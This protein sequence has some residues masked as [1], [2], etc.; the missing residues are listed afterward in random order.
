MRLIYKGLAWSSMGQD[1]FLNEAQA[2]WALSALWDRVGGCAEWDGRPVI[3]FIAA[4]FEAVES[5]L[6]A[7]PGSIYWIKID[8]LLPIPQLQTSLANLDTSH[9]PFFFRGP[10]TGFKY[11]KDAEFPVD[12]VTAT[13]LQL[14]RWEEWHEPTLDEFGCH[15]EASTFAFRQGFIERPV[16]DEWAL[17][18]RYWLRIASPAWTPLMVKGGI[19]LSHDIDVLRYYKNPGR[20]FRSLARKFFKEKRGLSSFMAINEGVSAFCDPLKDPCVT[21]IDVLMNF[22]EIRGLSTTFFFMASLPDVWDDGYDVFTPYFKVVR[23]RIR[24]RNHHLGWHPGYKAGRDELVLREEYWRISNALELKNFPA[25]HHFLRWSAADSLRR[26]AAL[27]C[28]YDGSIGYNYRNGFRASTAHPYQA[29]DHELNTSLPIQVRPLVAM[30]G[31][32]Q[33]DERPVEELVRLLRNRCEMVN[34]YFTLCIHNYSLMNNSE[35]LQSIGRGL[36]LQG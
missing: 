32:L 29:W 14:S 19:E 22:A 34:G 21:A 15:V 11:S 33:R 1:S 17:I 13:F 12:L 35:L 8:E 28:Q 30:D 10:K 18:V 31:P 36:D 27:G 3:E 25:R 24:A 5:D 6:L 9:L 23:D 7:P 26:L 16:I 4:S 2:R 20:F